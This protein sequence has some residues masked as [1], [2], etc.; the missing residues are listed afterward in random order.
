MP[1]VADVD[2]SGVRAGSIDPATS[3]HSAAAKEL[4]ELAEGV[5]HVAGQQVRSFHG[6]EVAAAA[7]RGPVHDVVVAFGQGPDRGVAGE[8]RHGGRYLGAL[9]RLDPAASAL[10]VERA[11]ATMDRI[12]GALREERDE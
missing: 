7:E 3:R 4:A 9:R 12:A 11:S 2:R 8:Y 10:E 6:R 5:P 1:A